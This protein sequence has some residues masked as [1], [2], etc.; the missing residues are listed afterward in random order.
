MGKGEAKFH[1]SEIIP[2]LVRLIG[3]E[4]RELERKAPPIVESGFHGGHGQLTYTIVLPTQAASIAKVTHRKSLEG[5]DGI[6]KVR[7]KGGPR[8]TSAAARK[9]L[10]T[11]Q[12]GAKAV[13]V[14]QVDACENEQWNKVT[15]HFNAAQNA[16]YCLLRVLGSYFMDNFG[17]Q[18]NILVDKTTQE[19]LMSEE[20]DMSPHHSRVSTG[21]AASF[22]LEDAN[23][24]FETPLGVIAAR[25]STS[26][27]RPGR[28]EKILVLVT[29]YAY[30]LG[31]RGAVGRED[32]GE[33]LMTHAEDTKNRQRQRLCIKHI[34][35]LLDLLAKKC[36]DVQLVLDIKTRPSSFE[37]V[38]EDFKHLAPDVVRVDTVDEELEHKG[39]CVDP[40]HAAA[41]H[42]AIERPKKIEDLFEVLSRHAQI[43][44]DKQLPV[45]VLN[46]ATLFQPITANLVQAEAT[47]PRFLFRNSDEQ[48]TQD[49]AFFLPAA[50]ASI[51]CE[52]LRSDMFDKYRLNDQF[53]VAKASTVT[54]IRFCGD[55]AIEANPFCIN[56]GRC[57]GFIDPEKWKFFPGPT[58]VR[59]HDEAY[60]DIFEP[61]QLHKMIELCQKLAGVHGTEKR[62]RR[63]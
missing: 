14:S 19:H 2:D 40:T 46:V 30:Y 27:D 36:W 32:V 43:W 25:R 29:G 42:S 50:E 17:V 61:G 55:T 28:G 31:A 22:R 53:K 10:E 23:G 39:A 11:V 45:L 1:F 47:S 7:W 63:P 51:F 52:R 24:I 33:V 34:R 26:L 49:A 18:Y 48:I 15:L 4:I 44:R 60:G 56:P 13:V 38:E 6:V 5:N 54:G 20:F 41:A 62:I 9:G 12:S 16:E 57:I 59:N 37:Y 21:P 35:I 58:V 3:P 8:A